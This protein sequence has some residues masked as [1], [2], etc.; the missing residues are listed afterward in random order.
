MGMW[1]ETYG[2]TKPYYADDAVCIVC[3]DCREVLPSVTAKSIDLGITS[4]P[5]NLG[6]AHHTG[7]VRHQSYDDDAPEGVYQAN[8]IVVLDMLH[9]VIKDGGSMWYQHKNR[10]K[11]GFQISPYQWL[12][13]TKWSVKQEIV[14][15]NRSQN[16]DKCRF[17]P[18]TERLYW[19]AKL[20]GTK[21]YNSIG[22]NDDWHIEPVGSKGVHT[23]A[24]P[25]ELVNNI[26]VCFEDVSVVVDP[27]LGSG[28]T[29]YCAKKLNRHCIGIEIVE[30]YCE[31]AASRCSQAVFDLVALGGKG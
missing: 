28:T 4:P 6:N 30:K 13:G 9:R 21:L 15:R 12:L 20:Q 17:Y 7:N 31:I 5:F 2:I 11:D 14:W 26:L 18:M 22:K 10:I 25:E 19:L 27:Y 8:Q 3:G 23:R 16:F 1:Y 29:A 24:F